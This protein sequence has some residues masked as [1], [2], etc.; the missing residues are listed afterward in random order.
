M[1][2]FLLTLLGV[3]LVVI[4]LLLSQELPSR[5]TVL[6]RTP[7]NEQ[8]IS[9]RQEQLRAARQEADTVFRQAMQRMTNLSRNMSG[10]GSSEWSDATLITSRAHAR[11]YRRTAR[12]RGR[13]ALD[14]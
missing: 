1:L 3:E 10:V 8:L 6:R 12:R 14:L 9:H 2:P 7:D 11:L 5:S 13:H 4:L